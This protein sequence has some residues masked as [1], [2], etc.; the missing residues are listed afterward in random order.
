MTIAQKIAEGYA[1]RFVEDFP[2]SR[3]RENQEYLRNKMSTEDVVE[4][5]EDSSDS[6][7]NVYA[8]SRIGFVESELKCGLPQRIGNNYSHLPLNYRTI[9]S[10]L[11]HAQEDFWLAVPED[12]KEYF[13]MMKGVF[14]DA[15]LAWKRGRILRDF[16]DA[17]VGTKRSR[18]NIV[19][20]KETKWYR[21]NTIQIERDKFKSE[22][23]L[24]VH[25]KS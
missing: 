18:R 12:E 4:E 24:V 1:S 20:I 14:E 15:V 19:K 11:Q 3:V 13:E 22:Y 17:V 25:D 9:S 2:L 5:F 8:F 16:E 10:A 21:L 7:L 6:G 23:L